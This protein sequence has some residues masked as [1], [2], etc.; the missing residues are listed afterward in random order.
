M[1]TQTAL[2]R[3]HHPTQTAH[4]PLSAG[5]GPL[6][7]SFPVRPLDVTIRLDRSLQRLV[8]IVVE[9]DQHFFTRCH[10]S[11]T[12]NVAVTTNLN[13]H[14]DLE[15][16]ISIVVPSPQRRWPMWAKVSHGE[17]GKA[18]LGDRRLRATTQT[19]IIGLPILPRQRQLLNMYS[20]WASWAASIG[21]WRQF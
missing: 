11:Y 12:R 9:S 7:P 16:L 4:P 15:F 18:S 1:V 2:R 8:F 10:L 17:M 21:R 5:L 6:R 20:S 13:L 19:C 14:L 3:S